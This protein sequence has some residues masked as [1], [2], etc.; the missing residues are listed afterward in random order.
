LPDDARDRLAQAHPRGR[1][2]IPSD[3]AAAA[4]FLLSDAATWLTGVTVNV[5]GG[6][7]MT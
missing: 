4:V 1:I 7:V 2:G 3:I 6:Q 5:N